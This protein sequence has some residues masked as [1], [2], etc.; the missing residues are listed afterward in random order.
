MYKT[1]RELLNEYLTKEEVLN[2]LNQ[3]IVDS[4]RVWQ[5]DDEKENLN[6]LAKTRLNTFLSAKVH[7]DVTD[8]IAYEI[9][10]WESIKGEDYWDGLH[11]RIWEELYD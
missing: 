4:M 3:I 6:K 7:D 5:A 8:L 10:W 9:E 11:T 2:V 1:N